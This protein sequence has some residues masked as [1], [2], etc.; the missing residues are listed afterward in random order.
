MVNKVAVGVLAMVVVASL[1]VG[2][3][4]GMQL[5][6]GGG[7]SAPAATAPTT[8]GGT[9]TPASQQ[10]NGGD[11]ATA[12]ATPAEEQIERHTEIP[13]RQFDEEEIAAHVARFANEE[14]EA[15]NRTRLS[16]GDATAT[17][18][19]AMA[20]NHSVAMADHGDTAH[21]ID[22]LT[23]TA[24][25][26]D[27][28]LFERCKFKSPE[29]SYI[30]TPDEKF[31]LIGQTYAGTEYRDDGETR[32]N[33]DEEDVARAIVDEWNESSTYS[34]RLLVRGPT[35]MGVG[36]EVTSEGTAYATIDVCA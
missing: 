11:A 20:S 3:L 34:D 27:N 9:E 17:R 24:R 14:R 21:N 26:K 23:T 36:V 18:V 12:T 13:A 22:G 30:S 10:S 6:G 1:G 8:D 25:Y 4:I 29:G 31:E 15:Q 33:A 28:D 7:A 19:S 5:G 35:R 32:F 16:T 2:I